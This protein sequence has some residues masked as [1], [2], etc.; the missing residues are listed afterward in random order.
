MIAH[1]PARHLVEPASGAPIRK[2][3]TKNHMLGE[4]GP[5]WL[6]FATLRFPKLTIDY[7]PRAVSELL[8][9]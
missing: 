5:E 3:L 7:V 8:T 1:A 4:E 6:F 2:L 9:P